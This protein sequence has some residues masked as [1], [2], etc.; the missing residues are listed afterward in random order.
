MFDW[1]GAVIKVDDTQP[2][3]AEGVAAGCITVGLTLSGNEA[4]LTPDELAVLSP[5]ERAVLHEKVGA[6]LKAAGADYIIETVADL[7][8]LIDMLER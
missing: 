5:N 6:K 4:G 8:Q 7:P 1:T 3:I 2:G